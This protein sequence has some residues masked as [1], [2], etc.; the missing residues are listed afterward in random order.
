MTWIIALVLTAVGVTVGVFVFGLFI[1]WLLKI[2]IVHAIGRG[3][4]L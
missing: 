3:L 1:G 2:A 4:N